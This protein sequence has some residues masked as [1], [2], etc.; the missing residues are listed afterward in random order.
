M[1]DYQF[2]IREFCQRH[3]LRLLT[4][5]A[6]PTGYEEAFGTFDP[7]CNTLYYN[8][9][10]LNCLSECEALFYLFHELRHAQQYF[11]Q[12]NFYCFLTDSL[13]YVILY[14]GT[15][16]KRTEN[17]WKTCKPEGSTAELSDIY[18]SLPYE[19]D[20]NQFA[21]QAVAKRVGSSEELNELFRQWMPHRALTEDEF[22]RIFAVIDRNIDLQIDK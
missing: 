13:Q 9:C 21:F 8:E 17:G 12:E 14:D 7:L 20:A 11:R 18:L 10:L 16:F 15:C 3:R 4:S 19:R 5:T 2:E 1:I 6:M 22:R